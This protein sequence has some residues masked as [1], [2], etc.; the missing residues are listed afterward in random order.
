LYQK[1]QHPNPPKGDKIALPVQV[2]GSA[3]AQ[4]L[5]GS[6]GHIPQA[7]HPNLKETP[8]KKASFFFSRW[9]AP[10]SLL[11]AGMSQKQKKPS[12]PHYVKII[13]PGRHP[14]KTPER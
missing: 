14:R 4:P 13:Y 2:E 3:E 11:H 8:V 5:S 1:K 12:S 6:G 7:Q 10:G 9:K